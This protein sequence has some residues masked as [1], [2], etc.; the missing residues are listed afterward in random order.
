MI[1]WS[2]GLV[3]VMI[4]GSISRGRRRAA[5]ETLRLDV[6][7]RHVDVA[8]E[9]ELDVTL[10]WPWREVEV[11]CC[12]PSTV[13]TASSRTSTTSV[14]MISGEAPSQETETLTIGKSTSGF[15]LIPRPRKTSPK[16]G[17]A[18]HAEADQREH[19]DPREDVVADRD[20]RQRHAGGDGPGDPPA[21]SGAAARRVSLTAAPAAS[22]RR[23]L[24]AD[25]L[26]G[27]AVGQAVRALRHDHLAGL[28]ARE[29]LDDPSPVRRPICTGRWRALPSSTT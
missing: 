1:G 12:T 26:D 27:D 25:R 11:I 23:R 6:L 8:A 21:G 18:D 3:L 24:P 2:S 9:V 13:V 10:A 17:V 14:S 7:Q 22:A 28:E 15:W 16:P 5:C 4:G 19:Q 29:D 20:V